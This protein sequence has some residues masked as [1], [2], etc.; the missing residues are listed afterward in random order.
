MSPFPS[1]LIVL[2]SCPSPPPPRL[3]SERHPWKCG[4]VPPLLVVVVPPALVAAVRAERGSSLLVSSWARTFVVRRGGPSPAS[5]KGDAHPK[6]PHPWSSSPLPHPWIL[7]SPPSLP[8][9]RC[10]ARRATEP[11]SRSFASRQW[12]EPSPWHHGPHEQLWRAVGGGGGR[13]CPW[14]AGRFQRLRL[15]WA[16]DGVGRVDGRGA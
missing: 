7:P 6:T 15:G 16:V 9:R 8:F 11:V 1:C 10:G 4:A 12:G 5:P 3:P 2:L 14:A 13:R